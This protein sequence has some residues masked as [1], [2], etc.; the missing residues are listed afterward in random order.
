M[1]E[2]ATASDDE[3]GAAKKE[4][5]V[6]EKEGGE[7]GEGGEGKKK[8][9]W[10]NKYVVVAFHPSAHPPHSSTTHPLTINRWTKDELKG[11]PTKKVRVVLDSMEARHNTD[12]LS[13]TL[14]FNYRMED[15]DEDG[16]E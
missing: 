6:A 4:K 14:A 10:G 1:Q 9:G 13:L 16:G 8:S 5:A 15:E 11:L 7:G 12:K 3:G 2:D